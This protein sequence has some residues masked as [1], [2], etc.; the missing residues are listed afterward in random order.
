MAF[1][2]CPHCGFKNIYSLQAPNFCGGCG[3]GLNILSASKSTLTAPGRT[4]QKK[5]NAK[6]PS[7]RRARAELDDPDGTDVYEV[8]NISN[9]SYSIEQD[10]NKFNLKDMIPLD[11]I[12]SIEQE[13]SP[14]PT[15][16]KRKSSGRKRKS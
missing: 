13:P 14:K 6:I 10:R 5:A 3:E 4:L 11:Q 12:E 8:P 7:S 2:Y 9:F 1:S 15:P 16:K